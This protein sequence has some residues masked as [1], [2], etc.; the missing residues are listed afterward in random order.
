MIFSVIKSSN[1]KSLSIEIIKKKKKKTTHIETSSPQDHS[2]T[3]GKRTYSNRVKISLLVKIHFNLW[4]P[5][6]GTYQLCYIP[7]E[8]Q[9]YQPMNNVL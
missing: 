1:H 6:I 7:N 2:V 8:L 4:Y 3:N 9:V 5:G